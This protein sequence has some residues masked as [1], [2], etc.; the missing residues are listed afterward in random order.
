MTAYESLIGTYGTDYV[1]ISHRRIGDQTLEEFFRPGG[2]SL[3]ELANGQVF[4]YR[5]LEGRLL[6]SSYIPGPGQPGYAA[7]LAELRSLFEAH[8]SDGQVTLVYTTKVYFGRPS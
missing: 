3:R 2:Y 4:D 6:S 5:G 8:Q 1:S 7:M